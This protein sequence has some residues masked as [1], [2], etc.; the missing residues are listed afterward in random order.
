MFYFEESEWSNYSYGDFLKAFFILFCPE[1]SRGWTSLGLHSGS[2]LLRWSRTANDMAGGK[3]LKTANEQT[4]APDM[5]LKLTLHGPKGK[6]DMG[7][8]MTKVHNDMASFQLSKTLGQSLS[9]CKTVVGENS[10]QN[11]W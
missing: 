9:S 6:S 1:L 3:N 2:I 11:F 10:L 5:H 4:W 7:L 8:S